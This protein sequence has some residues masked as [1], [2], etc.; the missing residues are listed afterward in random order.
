MCRSGLTYAHAARLRIPGLALILALAAGAP[1]ATVTDWTGAA[2]DSLWT[3]PGNWDNGVPV[4]GFAATF[5]GAG[6]GFTSISLG[7]GTQPINTIAFSGAP[8]A[9]TLGTNPNDLFNFDSGGTVSVASGITTAQTIAAGINASG[10]LTVTNAGTGGLTF[11]GPLSLGG[12]MTVTNSGATALTTFGGTISGS[13]GITPGGGGSILFSGNNSYSGITNL[14]SGTATNI[15]IGSNTAF[16]TGI[17]QPNNGTNSPLQAFGGDRTIANQVN[18]NTGFTVTNAATPHNLTFTGPF[19]FTSAQGRTA[20][21]N[22]FGQV[23]TLGG[24]PNSSTITLSTGNGFNLALNVSNNSTGTLPA[25]LVLNDVIQDNPLPPG[26]PNTIS[27]N[28]NGNNTPQGNLIINSASTY[29][30]STT[31]NAQNSGTFVALNVEIGT[32]TVLNGS[33]IVSGPFGKGTVIMNNGNAPPIFQPF[34]ADRTIANPLT[35]TSGFFAATAPLTGTGATVDPSG[36]AH[37]LNF[38]GAISDPGKVI[39]N[40]MASGVALYLGSAASPSVIT[41]SGTGTTKFQTTTGAASTTIIYDELTGSTANLT[42]QNRAIVQLF[43]GANNYG[44]AT[45]VTSNGVLLATNTSGSATGTSTVSATG[46]GTGSSALGTGGT[47]G[48]N[49]FITGA[50]TISSTAAGSQ[51]GILSPGMNGP[52][53]LGVGSMA[54]NPFGRYTFEYNQNDST[55]GNSINDYVNGAGSL[56][57]TNLNSTA[58]FDV[59]LSP[60][61]SGPSAQAYTLATFAGGIVANG[62]PFANGADVTSLFSFSGTYPS[63]PD[64]M[65]AAGPGGSGQSLVLTFAPTPEPTGLAIFGL[66]AAAALLRR[67]R[68]TPVTR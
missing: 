59:N 54:F 60:V 11:G 44:G 28:S 67:R 1:A 15:E 64:L 41:M 37:N 13:F 34:G 68:I 33:S 36:V 55:V 43:N 4:S 63:A 23:V 31:F 26:T 50:I 5:N 30:G 2:G 24:S 35:L 61:V 29:A 62:T 8:A 17:L 65:V 66:G 51:G 16:G 22:N 47:L 10:A 42:V 39:T 56:D 14:S 19:L 40:N 46:A 18:M 25:T 57:L 32:N 20:A 45:A 21:F 9:Y 3:T 53:T 38:T 58:P 12:T 52:G 7:N 6:G 49:G 27:Y 48:G